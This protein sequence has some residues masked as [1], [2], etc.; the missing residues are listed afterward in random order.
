MIWT[1][2]Q[3]NR[4]LST[5][6][7]SSRAA[8]TN[9][10]ETSTPTASPSGPT[11]A[12]SRWVVSPNPQPRSRTLSPGCGGRAFIAAS[13]CAPSP[14]VTRS[15]YCTKRSK[16]GPLQ[17]SV[18]SLFE[19]AICS[20]AHMVRLPSGLAVVERA[21]AANQVSVQLEEPGHL[22]VPCRRPIL[23]P[24]PRALDQSQGAFSVLKQFVQLD[25]LL[26]ASGLAGRPSPR[27]LPSLPQALHRMKLNLRIEH[28]NKGVQISLVERANELPNRIVAH[29]P[30]PDRDG[31][32]CTFFAATS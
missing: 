28:S 12:A 8:A 23:V 4:M 3:R 19:A 15:R 21:P 20:I 14:A 24:M 11:R 32:S 5:T 6:A 2:P 16:S 13:P 17:A 30:R 27:R 22:V 9:G 25:R 7:P 10:S 18:A 26:H 31:T 1:S 29:H